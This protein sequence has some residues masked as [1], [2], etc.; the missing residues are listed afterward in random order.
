MDIRRAAAQ[1]PM[2]G[3]REFAIAVGIL[4]A[5]G[6]AGCLRAGRKAEGKPRAAPE[7]KAPAIGKESAAEEQR[8]Q[9]VT[10]DVEQAVREFAE[11]KV[12][13]R[14]DSGGNVH[15]A[16]GRMSFEADALKQN[17]QHFV[18]H[19]RGQR[20]SSTKGALIQR[21]VICGTMTPGV[22]VK[23]DSL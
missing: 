18:N 16:V 23:M 4:L 15:I 13:Y 2:N 19:I 6:A 8:G 22:D 17:I 11:G 14:N 5:L 7:L 21:I 12:E 1:P 10:Q 9:P 3:A 20:P